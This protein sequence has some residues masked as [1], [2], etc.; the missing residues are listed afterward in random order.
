MLM[1]N[2]DNAVNIVTQTDNMKRYHSSYFQWLRNNKFLRE[3]QHHDSVDS[4]II[5]E[6]LRAIQ[7]QATPTTCVLLLCPTYEYKYKYKFYYYYY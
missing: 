3:L 1:M 6:E 4:E 5:D 7:L 2:D